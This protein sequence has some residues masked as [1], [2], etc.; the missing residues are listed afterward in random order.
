[1][2]ISFVIGAY[3]LERY[4][5]LE[6]LFLSIKAQTYKNY[7]V[8]FISDGNKEL[9]TKVRGLLK[10]VAF[11]RSRSFLNTKKGISHLRNL[12]V[13]QVTGDIVAF[14]DDDAVLYPYWAR[15]VVDTFSRFPHAGA[16]TGDIE[17]YWMFPKA[18]W[19]PRELYWVL[20]CSYSLTPRKIQAVRNGFGTN[21]CFRKEIFSQVGQFN[22]ALGYT[23]TGTG[24]KIKV[25]DGEEVDYCLRMT[26]RTQK[27]VL[28]NPRIRV[29]HKVYPFRIRFMHVMRKCYGDGYAKALIAFL[30][31]KN[32][33]LSTEKAYLLYLFKV[34]YP[35]EFQHLFFHP[36]LALRR[37]LFVSAA[38]FSLAVGYFSS[39]LRR[40][41]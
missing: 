20:S 9:L 31:R 14:V 33:G 15:A 21:L 30:H 22:P 5:D 7:E 17:P 29:R 2:K 10:Q 35:R 12:G 36:T 6:E 8:L 37:M 11:P 23:P 16:V 19:F 41:L 1:M 24:K 32:K 40:M 4:K 3:T 13:S 34:F 18:V 28:F 39:F 26:E 38:L 25:I 27:I